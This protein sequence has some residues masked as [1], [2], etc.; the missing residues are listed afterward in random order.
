MLTPCHLCVFM[1]VHIHTASPAT[2]ALVLKSFGWKIRGGVSDILSPA[3]VRSPIR[4]S[5]RTG[6]IQKVE[7]S[8]DTDGEFYAKQAVDS[9]LSKALGFDEEN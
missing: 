7:A 4:T 3:A 1:F 9:D 8:R 2:A 5:R 6:T